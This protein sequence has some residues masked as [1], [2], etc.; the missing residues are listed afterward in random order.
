MCTFWKGY[1][2]WRW[3]LSEFNFNVINYSFKT[4]GV[5]CFFF[6]NGFLQLNTFSKMS[7]WSTRSRATRWAG[8]CR[9]PL[10]RGMQVCYQRSNSGDT[11]IH[12]E[13]VSNGFIFHF[14]AVTSIQTSRWCCH[15]RISP[16]K[17]PLSPLLNKTFSSHLY[18]DGL[19]FFFT[20]FF[21]KLEGDW[22]AKVW[23]FP[24]W[25][26]SSLKENAACVQGK[27][28]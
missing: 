12:A 17:F 10:E 27:E 23:K 18:L 21:D 5:L 14:W 9:G 2:R 16:Y 7:Q 13:D 3:L 25:I 1:W 6:I 8:A 26:F 15:I 24:L 19:V 20:K 22:F 4:S 11:N 28:E